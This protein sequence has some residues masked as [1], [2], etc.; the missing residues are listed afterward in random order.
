MNVKNLSIEVPSTPSN[1]FILMGLLEK[2]R[3]ELYNRQ[4]SIALALKQSSETSFAHISIDACQ[5][6]GKQSNQSRAK[7]ER[8]H[9]VSPESRLRFFLCFEVGR[10]LKLPCLFG[11]LFKCIN[12]GSNS[13][14]SVCRL[15]RSLSSET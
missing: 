2:D 11:Q 9:T 10:L 15:L 12:L 14:Y 6:K 3:H 1:L 7:I 8:L 13:A 4:G 5:R